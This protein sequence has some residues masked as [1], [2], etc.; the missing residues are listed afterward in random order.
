MSKT[1][2]SIAVG[3]LLISSY[4]QDDAAAK[5]NDAIKKTSEIKSCGFM[6][7]T[8]LQGGE[9]GGKPIAT[10]GKW[11]AETGM[12]GSAAGKIDF[13]KVGEKIVVKDP[14]DGTWKK[15]EDFATSGQEKG[16]KIG[17]A[18]KNIVTPTESILALVDG[19]KDIKEGDKEKVES[20]ECTVYSGTLTEEAAK[21]MVAGARGAGKA[22]KQKGN[23]GGDAAGG[24]GEV[25][26]WV[27][28]SG[29]VNKIEITAKFK[30]PSKEGGDATEVTLARTINIFDHD[31]TKVEIPEEAKKALGD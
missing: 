10:D 7:T 11:S 16:K 19:V 30:M 22:G 25:K 9:K 15:S 5:L 31:K 23:K 13:V 24:T 26:V 4:A 14:K 8:T 29:L 20:V 28:E 17:G 6:I 21:K 2:S 1:L 12:V 18:A 27:D 3:L